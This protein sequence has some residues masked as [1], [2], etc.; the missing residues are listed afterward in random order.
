[1]ARLDLDDLPPK[2]AALLTGLADGEEL[3]LVQHG[4]VVGRLGAVAAESSEAASP[5]LPPDQQV[6]EVF[7]NFRSAIE[8]EF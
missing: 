2:I 3:L 8:D 6:R 5:D 7:E 1:M 4:A